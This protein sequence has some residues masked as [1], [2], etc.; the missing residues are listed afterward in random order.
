[1]IDYSDRRAVVRMLETLSEELG[2]NRV[3][4]HVYREILEALRPVI[5]EDL[6][7]QFRPLD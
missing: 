4:L 2:S 7:D 6:Y 1:M 3:Q 5:G